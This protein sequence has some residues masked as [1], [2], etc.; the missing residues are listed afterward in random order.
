MKVQRG[1]FDECDES[2]EG[3]VSGRGALKAPRHDE[4]LVA[5]P[6]PRREERGPRW[7]AVCSAWQTVSVLAQ[8]YAGLRK[9]LGTFVSGDGAWPARDLMW[10]TGSL[11]AVTF[12]VILV[13]RNTAAL[14]KLYR[15][16][17]GAVEKSRSSSRS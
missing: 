15:S 2:G 4:K 17:V 10:I 16:E 14:R 1:L 7:K 5:A 6:E 12:V 13:A 9:I 8:L 3:D 11:A